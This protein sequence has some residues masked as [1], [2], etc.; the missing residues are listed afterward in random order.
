[1]KS[2][3][4]NCTCVRKCEKRNETG[5]AGLDQCKFLSE[6]YLV[7]VFANSVFADDVKMKNSRCK[8]QDYVE[9]F[10][11][12]DISYDLWYSQNTHEND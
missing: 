9:R 10:F 12:A 11:N 8:F 2:K 4:L 3:G 6:V 5:N 1:M 7:I